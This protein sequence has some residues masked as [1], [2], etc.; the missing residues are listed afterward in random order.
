M[1]C[2]FLL[3]LLPAYLQWLESY[4]SS[5]WQKGSLLLAYCKQ[6]LLAYC[7]EMYVPSAEAQGSYPNHSR[8]S[9]E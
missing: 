5:F 2:V 8:P 7:P 6:A 4:T 1:S 9:N 3:A